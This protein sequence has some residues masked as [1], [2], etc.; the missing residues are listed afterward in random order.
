MDMATIEK[1]FCSRHKGVKNSSG[2][3]IPGFFKFT[4]VGRRPVVTRTGQFFDGAGWCPN[5]QEK[6]L[7]VKWTNCFFLHLCTGK[8][9]ENMMWAGLSNFLILTSPGK[10]KL[11]SRIFSCISSAS[12][13]LM[14]AGWRDQ[15]NFSMAAYPLFQTYLISIIDNR[16]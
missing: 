6:S 16:K 14:R 13:N 3:K 11:L 8:S 5:D 7:Y 15:N 9:T 10:N 1:L 12:E 2:R 4:S